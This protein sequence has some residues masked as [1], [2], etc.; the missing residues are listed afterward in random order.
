M[1]AQAFRY[2]RDKDIQHLLVIA[3][4]VRESPGD[5]DASNTLAGIC[6]GIP[7]FGV[8]PE[9]TEAII[10]VLKRALAELEPDSEIAS[11]TLSALE[12]HLPCDLAGG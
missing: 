7:W 5:L 3:D 10:N 6:R 11:L 2:H 1:A 9:P 8:V 12:A 4:R